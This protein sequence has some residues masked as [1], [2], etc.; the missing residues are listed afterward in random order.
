MDLPVISRE[1]IRQ[2]GADAFDRGLSINDHGMNPWAAAVADWQVGY[3]QRKAE[4]AVDQILALAMVMG[5][6]T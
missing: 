4:C 2:R 5:S 6:P 3:L 1:T